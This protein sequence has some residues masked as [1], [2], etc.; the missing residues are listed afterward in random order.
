MPNIYIKSEH[1]YLTE[2]LMAKYYDFHSTMF[3]DEIK[4]CVEN[5]GIDYKK[6]IDGVLT[7]DYDQ[8][9]RENKELGF[10]ITSP[11]KEAIYEQFKD[12]F[13]VLEEGSE[14]EE[15]ITEDDLVMLSLIFMSYVYQKEIKGLF[16][17][18]FIIDALDIE[19]DSI[20]Q[21][22]IY[23]EMLSLY[24]IILESKTKKHRGTKL[25]I[26]YKQDK[27][28]INSC[29]WFLD[30]ME[31]YFKER[32]PDLTLED[33]NQLL[34]EKKGKAGRKFNNRI[35]NNLIWG[36]YQLLYNHHSRF[37]NSKIRISE[38]ICQFIIDYLDY[39]NIPHDLILVNVRDWLKDMLKRGYTPRWDLPWRNTFSNI[40]EKQPETFEEQLNT[41]L[42]RYNI[43]NL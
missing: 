20:L 33:I 2:P 7:V 12:Y 16:Q 43:S 30:D 15:V 17:Q 5:S 6:R 21:K 41:P 31:K 39:L 4:Q 8:T 36:T 32:F 22:H 19:Y 27:I 35:T 1:L 10:N 23:P 42:R 13:I 29:A 9:F 37:K 34:P 40:Q 11:Y 38:E 28:D 18:S 14:E 24:K 25:T 26:T 3:I